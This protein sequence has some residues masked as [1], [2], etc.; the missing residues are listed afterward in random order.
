MSQGKTRS[1]LSRTG[2]I[3]IISVSSL[4]YGDTLHQSSIMTPH[5]G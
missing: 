4:V 2:K 5:L 3:C 1:K